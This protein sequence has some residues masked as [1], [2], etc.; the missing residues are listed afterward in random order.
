MQLIIAKLAGLRPSEYTNA[1]TFI[2]KVT[3]LTALVDG[4]H[5]LKAFVSIL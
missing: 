5:D 3:L 2:E 4:V 1:F